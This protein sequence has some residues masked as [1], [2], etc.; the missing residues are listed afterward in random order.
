MP[1][2]KKTSR[3]QSKDSKAKKSKDPSKVSGEGVEESQAKSKTKSGGKSKTMRDGS[4]E[5]EPEEEAGEEQATESKGIEEGDRSSKK[6]GKKSKTGSKAEESGLEKSGSVAKGKKKAK[7]QSKL[8]GSGNEEVDKS[9]VSR[10]K[11]DDASVLRSKVIMPE[12]KPQSA[13]QKS[14]A[15]K[16]S[17]CLIVTLSNCEFSRDL[18]YFVAVQLGKNGHRRRTEVSSNVHN[19]SFRTNTFTIPLEDKPIEHYQSLYF[20]AFIV[21]SVQDYS[22]EHADEEHAGEA[23]LLGECSLNLIPHRFQLW[24]SNGHGIKQSMKFIRRTGTVEGTV[25][26]FVVNVK[27]VGEPKPQE[28]EPSIVESKILPEEPGPEDNENMKYIVRPLP[29]SDGYNF[30]WRVRIDFRSAI[31]LMMN[32]TEPKSLPST[33][34]EVGIADVNNER[35]HDS[36]LQVT[37]TIPSERNPI[38]NQ[39]LL[40]VRYQD[41][42]ASKNIYLYVALKNNDK[43]DK[44]PFDAM[45]FPINKMK[46]F[47][48]YHFEC[49]SS[50]YEFKTRGAFWMS[51]VL[52]EKDP[53]KTLEQ[54]SNI[55]VHKADHNPLPREKICRFWIAMTLFNYVPKEIT[56]TKVDLEKVKVFDGLLETTAKENSQRPVYLST[57]LKFPADEVLLI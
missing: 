55:V 16:V 8:E 43:V 34:F 10:S 1:P 3:N 20:T 23:R 9:A 17:N 15:P 7:T 52:E 30:H 45:W 28:Q 11:I 6:T 31:D 21:L 41:E 38:W 13:V 4:G 25:G 53:K 12:D 44:K 56:F 5:E 39:Q 26:R 37:K 48:P 54:Y 46:P 27:Y 49:Q 2:K 57:M 36:L 14:N 47:Y 19:P 18:N 22:R 42:D 29:K 33:F 32:S 35:P 50:T 24:D 51:M 40:L